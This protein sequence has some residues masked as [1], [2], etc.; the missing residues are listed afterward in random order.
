MIWQPDLNMPADQYTFN[1][2]L[3]A[4]ADTSVEAAIYKVDVNGTEEKLGAKVSSGTAVYSAADGVKTT[5]NFEL[6]ETGC[7]AALVLTFGDG[8]SAQADNVTLKEA[9]LVPKVDQTR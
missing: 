2:D 3:Y 7:N 8:S 9:S 4:C 6:T 1:F 5:W